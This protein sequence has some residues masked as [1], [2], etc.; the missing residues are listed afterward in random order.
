MSQIMDIAIIGQGIVCPG[1]TDVI[2]YWRNIEAKRGVAQRVA[3][4]RWAADPDAVVREGVSPDKAI[5]ATACLI[6]DEVRQLGGFPFPPELLK[7]LDPLYHYTLQASREALTPL[8]LG[9]VDPKRSGVI[10]AAIALPTDASSRLTRHLFNPSIIAGT[11]SQP[12]P[13]RLAMIRR[14][15]I[16]ASRVT[17]L[18]AALL[19]AAFGF[20]GTTYTLDAACAS[21]LYALKLACDELVANRAD[22]MVTG[23]VSRPDCL[24]T[25]VGFSQLRALSPSGRCA[26]FDADADGLVVGEGAGIL[27]LKR[28]RDAIAAED[29]ILGVIRGIGLS[30][31]MRGNLL[32]PDSEGQL[33]AMRTAYLQ[34]EWSPTD[35]DLIECHGTGTPA[36]DAVEADSLMALWSDASWRP[37]QCPIGSVKSM[38]GHLL[39]GAGAAGMIKVLCALQHHTLPPALNFKRFNSDSPLNGGPFRVQTEPAPWV[40]RDTDTPRR[41]AVSA[42]GFGG[43]NAHV[44]VEE[45]RPTAD[46]SSSQTFVAEPS[47]PPPIAIVGMAAAFGELKDLRQFQQ[48]VFN[49]RTTIGERP[50]HRWKLADGIV[51]AHLQGKGAAGAYMAEIAIRS[52]QFQVPPKEIPDILPQQLLMLK[53]G[54]DALADAELPIRQ[55]RPRMGATIGVSFDYEATNFHLRWQLPRQV[56]KWNRTHDLGL[57]DT[58]CDRWAAALQEEIGPP[59]TAT[60][61]LGALGGIVASRVAREFKLGGPSFIVSQEEASGLRAVEIAVRLLQQAEVDAMLVGGVDLCGDPRTVISLSHLS[62]LSTESS[63]RS[64]DRRADGTLPGEGAAAVVLKRLE[65]AIADGDRIYAVI[66]GMGSAMGD[67]IADP[68]IYPAIYAG[69]LR[70]SLSEAD[71]MPQQVDLFETHGSGVPEEDAL[72]SEALRSLLPPTEA[73]RC[74]IGTVKPIIGHSGAT[75]GLASLIKAALSLHH[76]LLCP[77]PSF[78][79]PADT[80]LKAHGLHIPIYPSH[81]MK[82]RNDGPRRASVA[83][84]TRD[85]GCAHLLLEEVGEKRVEKSTPLAIAA[86]QRPLGDKPSGLF[87]LPAEDEAALHRAVTALASQVTADHPLEAIAREWYQRHPLAPDRPKVALATKSVDHLR[88]LLAEMRDAVPARSERL[89]EGPGGI[90][91]APDPLGKKGQTAF[92]F[93]GSGNHYLGMGRGIGL[94]WPHILREMGASTALLRSQMLPEYYLPW[95]AD[96]RPGWESDARAQIEADVLRMIF[97]QVVHGGLMVKVMGH[98]GLTADA[99]IGYS[100][101]ESAAHFAMGIWPERGE[102]LKRMQG[103][104][105]FTTQLAGP[106]L[107]ARHQWKIADD[108]SFEWSVAV[109][110]HP[111]SAVQEAVRRFPRTRL[112]IVNTYAECVIGGDRP[113]VDRA[114]EALGGDAH[115]L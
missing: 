98:F 88:H 95:R 72:E 99:A 92:V 6:A 29:P 53:I 24:Y 115:F 35:I 41:A 61:T 73:A 83:A 59:L 21:S 22:L 76:R 4:E 100:L 36:G 39:T 114:I 78:T 51:N 63:I 57:S 55:P 26:P 65:D 108:A 54:A 112:L 50:P 85:G 84:M 87:L 103:L 46:E 38:I 94:Q 109:V 101:G 18:P 66:K 10:L 49:G 14:E 107:A 12:S 9:G 105:L 28:L 80:D 93:P 25:Q 70:H 15:E 37:A 62:Q 56:R 32:A 31:D 5:G 81:W 52:G 43:I 113:Q 42:F 7:Q 19:A 67:A 79:E 75:A 86:R 48:A 20:R 16:L 34:A 96:W 69:S 23:G 30:N 33:R 44:L 47:S 27:V 91:V 40:A 104:D 74:A 64:F 111:K 45:Y 58:K 97:G 102:M 71:L 2:Q 17:S 13:D 3:R 89:I 77:H 106:C 60:R 110:P 8:S 11:I 1:A 90:A 68:A 82:D